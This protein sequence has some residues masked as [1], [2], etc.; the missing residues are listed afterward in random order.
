MSFRISA[1]SSQRETNLSL[2][3]RDL[4]LSS[5]YLLPSPQVPQ[6][7]ILVLKGLTNLH[8]FTKFL[9]VAGNKVQEGKFVKV[10]GTLIA[11]FYNLVIT[12]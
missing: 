5:I 11:H 10:F 12:L 7:P 2:L 9:Q 1:A 3:S 8:H 4:S 6:F